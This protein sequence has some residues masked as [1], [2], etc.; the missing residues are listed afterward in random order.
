MLNTKYVRTTVTLPEELVFELK[1][2]ALLTKKTVKDVVTE[3]L[4]T[5]LYTSGLKREETIGFDTDS[6]YGAWGKGPLSKT[7][8]QKKLEKVR[9]LAGGI[10][11]GKKAKEVTPKKINEL[12]DERY[13]KVLS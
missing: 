2:R 8:M 9:L 6:L 12:L 10:R 3:G 4:K 11:L 5:Y 1:K 13:E 7:R